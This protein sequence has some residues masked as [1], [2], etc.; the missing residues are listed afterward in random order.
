M[1]L[2]KSI[3]P[4]LW[5]IPDVGLGLQDIPFNFVKFKFPLRIL[6]GTGYGFIFTACI[7]VVT[8]HFSR[9]R[10]F[11]IGL[12]LAAGSLGTMAFP[13]LT[14]ELVE[15][16][17][18]RGALVISGGI[19][20]N[21]C[22]AALLMRPRIYKWTSNPCSKRKAPIQK[23][24]DGEERAV[25]APLAVGK[26]RLYLK[27]FKR[28]KFMLLC[29]NVF[30]YS[31]SMSVLFTHIA[32]YAEHLNFSESRRIILVSVLGMAGFAGRIILG[33][34][35]L[36]RCLNTK[37]LYCGSC[38]L[39]GLASISIGSWRSFAG[40]VT[41]LMGYGFFAA[42]YGPQLSEMTYVA[43]GGDHFATGY[44]YVMFFSALGQ[45]FGAP[46]AGRNTRNVSN[47]MIA[48]H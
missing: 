14:R 32:S 11:I 25:Q 8:E 37:W 9:L 1:I 35:G 4:A 7:V 17:G 29:I 5:T 36:L 28:P 23:Q 41:G 2:F 20:L 38:F 34:L 39:A 16:Y 27:L 43:S 42:T 6:P 46:I 48:M 19:N 10:V 12:S 30:L 47:Y 15:T 44:G 13:W 33:A 18:W 45:I 21:V 40:L 22:V 24:T 3:L 31:V 26:T